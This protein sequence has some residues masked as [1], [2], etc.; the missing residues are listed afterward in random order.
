MCANDHSL[1][2]SGDL[3]DGKQFKSMA[4]ALGDDF[5]AIIDGFFESCVSFGNRLDESLGHGDVGRFRNICH[6]IKGASGL[7]GFCG[8]AEA[9]AAWENTAAGGHLSADP[10]LMETFKRLVSDTRAHVK[11]L[12]K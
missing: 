12:E 11:S 7:I 8:I 1:P 5:G 9:A 10:H 3:L 4:D 6:E 2:D